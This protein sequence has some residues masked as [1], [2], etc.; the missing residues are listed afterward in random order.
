MLVDGFRPVINENGPLQYERGIIGNTITLTVGDA[1][2]ITPDTG[3][4]YIEPADATDDN[5]YGVLVDLVDKDGFSYKT[6]TSNFDGTYTEAAD[7]DTYVS[8][9]DN[10]TVKKVQARV[11][12]AQGTIFSAKLDAA[13][14]T[15]TGSDKIGIFFDILT[16]DSTSLDESSVS[17]TK[18]TYQSVSTGLG[19]DSPVDPIYPGSTTRIHVKVIEV[20]RYQAQ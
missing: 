13:A 3:G 5:V 20:S 12:L 19:S 9:S 8:A 6:K 10:L 11:C 17:A 4:S 18:A 7:G 1:V 14:G 2:K 16:S 15:T